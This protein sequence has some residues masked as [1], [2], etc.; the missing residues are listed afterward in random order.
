MPSFWELSYRSDPSTDFYASWLKRRGIAHGCAF[1]VSFSYGSPFRGSKHLKPHFGGVNRLFQAKLKKSKKVHII[2]TTASISTTSCTVI[3]TTKCPSRV[4]PT[5]ASQIQ[6]GGRPPSWK[7][8]KI[9]IFR[10]RF[11]RFRRNLA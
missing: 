5:Q 4:V 9:V 11:K 8:R 7:N 3:K 1:L 6:D 2:K 10:L